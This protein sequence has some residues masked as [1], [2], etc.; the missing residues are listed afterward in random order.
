MYKTAYNMQPLCL[1]LLRLKLSACVNVC[2]LHLETS[3]MSAMSVFQKRL[4][5]YNVSYISIRL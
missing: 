1:S 4:F 2:A 5:V 3:E